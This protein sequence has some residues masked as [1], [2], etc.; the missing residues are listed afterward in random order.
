MASLKISASFE[1][2]SKEKLDDSLVPTSVKTF[3]KNQ[4]DLHQYEEKKNVYSLLYAKKPN[5][6][7]KHLIQSY[8]LNNFWKHLL[9]SVVEKIDNSKELI[10]LALEDFMGRMIQRTGERSL[11]FR[12][13]QLIKRIGHFSTNKSKLATKKTR[14]AGVYKMRLPR[15]HL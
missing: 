6:L 8:A 3:L 4:I 14:T 11:C 10:Q 15:R 12:A 7:L 1:E 5:K 2:M 9:L 13:M